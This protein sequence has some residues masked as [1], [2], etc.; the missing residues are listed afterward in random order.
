MKKQTDGK[1]KQ[2]HGA[3]NL[4]LLGVI[5]IAIASATTGVSLAI[6]HSSGDIYL[7]RSR[8]G[9]LPDEEEIEEDENE[10][11]EDYSFEKSGKITVEVLDEY[12]RELSEEVEAIDAYEKPFDESVL[13]DEGL[14][15]PVESVETVEGGGERGA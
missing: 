7:D 9:F 2:T 3:R 13:S 5:A 6:Y 8:P 15:I 4:V 1:V 11:T 14:G 10:E 12:L